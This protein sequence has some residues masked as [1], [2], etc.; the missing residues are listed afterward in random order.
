MGDF[1]LTGGEL[2]AMALTDAVS[3]YLPGVLGSGESTL[4][5]SFSEGLLE[6]P[7]YTRPRVYEGLEV[8]EVLINGDHA[9]I[10]A[11]RRRQALLVTAR[12]RPDLLPQASLSQEERRF[13]ENQEDA[14]CC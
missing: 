5:E 1:V 4:E 8:P 7:Q 9:K 10:K 12:L 2:A 14:P 3:R 6:Y 13:L 11:W